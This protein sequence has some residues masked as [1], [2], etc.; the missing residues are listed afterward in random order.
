M[1]VAENG[2]LL[3]EAL[4]N[5]LRRR[6]LLLALDNFEQV[7]GAALDRVSMADGS[8]TNPGPIHGGNGRARAENDLNT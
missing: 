4:A 5:F 2:R 8:W 6:Q 3:R 1:Q 7:I